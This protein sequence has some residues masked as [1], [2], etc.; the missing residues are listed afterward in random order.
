MKTKKIDCVEM[1]RKSKGIIFNEIKNMTTAEE[2]AFWQ[3]GTK[4]LQQRSSSI[5]NVLSSKKTSKR[6]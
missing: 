6:K 4:D 1:K 5:E 2:L 3:K